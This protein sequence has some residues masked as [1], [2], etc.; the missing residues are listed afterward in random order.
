MKRNRRMVFGWTIKKKWNKKWL[1][2]PMFC[3]GS[4]MC[5]DLQTNDT[6]RLLKKG[7]TKKKTPMLKL[8]QNIS[9]KGNNCKKWS[10][11][12][13]EQCVQTNRQCPHEHGFFLR[14]FP[15]IKKLHKRKLS[16]TLFPYCL[17]SEWTQRKFW[18][19]V[20]LPLFSF[21]DSE[22]Q[23]KYKVQGDLV[24]KSKCVG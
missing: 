6:C 12:L 5:V 9:Q 16:S 19:E 1:N 15:L 3:G 11:K 21:P 20:S 14:G 17:Q 18:I 2:R 13:H 23:F 22:T 10:F 7:G 8:S 4:R 24:V